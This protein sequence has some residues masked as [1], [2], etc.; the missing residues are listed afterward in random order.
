MLASSHFSSS[1]ETYVALFFLP[2]SLHPSSLATLPVDLRIR[3][4]QWH[5]REIELQWREED[6]AGVEVTRRCVSLSAPPMDVLVRHLCDFTEAVSNSPGIMPRLRIST[7]STRPFRLHLLRSFPS[8]TR[9]HVLF[10]QPFG[11][12]HDHIHSVSLQLRTPSL[13]ADDELPQAQLDRA[14]HA[15]RSQFGEY[16]T[17]FP[18]IVTALI[19]QRRILQVRSAHL[20]SNERLVTFLYDVRHYRARDDY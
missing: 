15:L 16:V 20:V 8:F 9:C 10:Q 19:T 1:S 6:E 17:S 18:L 3:T 2:S 7:V 13:R 14:A 5:H 12:S 11:T 4:S